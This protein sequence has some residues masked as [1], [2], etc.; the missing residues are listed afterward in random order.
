[1]IKTFLD[2]SNFYLKSYLQLLDLFHLFCFQ[3]SAW[4]ST[5]T[6]TKMPKLVVLHYMFKKKIFPN[7]SIEGVQF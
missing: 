2:S 4:I 6:F 7:S 1:M 3:T 5:D